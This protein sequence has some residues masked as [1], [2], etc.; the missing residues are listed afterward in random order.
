MGTS[1]IMDN[2][3]LMQCEEYYGCEDEIYGT[4]DRDIISGET[5]RTE[6]ESSPRSI[7]DIMRI[8]YNNE[9]RTRAEDRRSE[10]SI[11]S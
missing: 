1:N 2:F 7:T 3:D 11:E 10:I 5:T 9:G 6:R 4:E 8:G